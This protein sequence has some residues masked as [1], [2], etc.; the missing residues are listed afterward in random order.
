MKWHENTRMQLSNSPALALNPRPGR[1]GPE[2]DDRDRRRVHVVILPAVDRPVEIAERLGETDGLG[3][4]RPAMG[5]HAPFLLLELDAHAF[6]ARTAEG[7]RMDVFDMG[8]VAQIVAQEQVVG[9]DVERIPVGDR[10]TPAGGIRGGRKCLPDP[11]LPDRPSR[12][13]SGPGVRPPDSSSRRRW[14]G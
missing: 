9:L 1:S 8:G 2:V 4:E 10:P 5:S 7:R 13:R 14:A 6:R 3:I 12:S 11:P